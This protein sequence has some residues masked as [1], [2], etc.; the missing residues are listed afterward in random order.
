MIYLQEF[1]DKNKVLPK[2]FMIKV[3]EI[4]PVKEVCN[5]YDEDY[6]L[7]V[8][9]EE[10]FSRNNIWIHFSSDLIDYYKENDYHLIL[11]YTHS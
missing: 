5:I 8:I 6:G 11:T 3:C 2:N 4:F 7:E 9:E 1:L 10:D